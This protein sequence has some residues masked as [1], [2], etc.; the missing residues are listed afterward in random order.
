MPVSQ[1]RSHDRL[2]PARPRRGAPAPSLQARPD[3]G[4][5]RSETTRRRLLEAGLALFGEHGPQNVTSHAIAARAGYAS[6]T[7]YLHFKD[8]L[9]LFHELAE[10]AASE[11]ERRLEQAADHESTPAALMRVQAEAL[12]GFAEEHR[13]LL[14]IL[15]QPGGE[16]ADIGAGILARLAR[17]VSTKRRE[18]AASGLVCDCFHPE[19]LA[20]AVVGMWA[21]VLAWW[22]EDSTR[23]SREDLIRTLTHFQLHGDRAEQGSP[24][25]LREGEDFR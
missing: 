7:F 23:V 6:G 9:A 11:I 1:P 18:A 12:V 24:C 25:G 22:A 8:K 13:D 17:N 15:F 3:S 2:H 16:A 4:S 20:Q 14:R 5:S 21:H 10:E 19:A